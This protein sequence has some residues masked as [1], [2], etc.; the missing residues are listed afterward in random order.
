[1]SGILDGRTA[2]V[3][4]G[5]AGLGKAYA[6]AL[7]AAGASV[8]VNDVVAESARSTVDLITADGG[9]AVDVVAP[10][11]DSETAQRLV[12]TALAEFGGMDAIITNAGFLRDRSILKMTDDD[13]D[14]VLRVHVRGTFT[15]ARAAYASFKERGV[16]GR[17]DKAALPEQGTDIGLMVGQLARRARQAQ[18]PAQRLRAAGPT[19]GRRPG[20][21]RS[22]GILRAAGPRR[23]E[24]R[25]DAQRAPRGRRGLAHVGIPGRSLP[26]VDGRSVGRTVRSA[27]GGGDRRARAGDRHIEP[28]RRRGLGG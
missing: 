23:A 7:A 21:R 15:C 17:H 28:G 14:D 1:M 8:V 24:L 18:T 11:G 13:F 27:P 22:G 12:D 6:L 9:R 25:P 16:A 3:T 19:V 20:A 4:G 5:G 26:R 10:V 2:I